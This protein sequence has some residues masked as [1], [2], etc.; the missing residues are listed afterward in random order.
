MQ[1]LLG[2]CFLEIN[3]SNSCMLIADSYDFSVL[4]L[5]CRK[6]KTLTLQITV[7]NM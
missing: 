1:L 7:E 2:L 6:Q 4:S 5:S 3:N